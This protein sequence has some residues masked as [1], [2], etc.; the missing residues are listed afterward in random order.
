MSKI[1][2]GSDQADRASK[3]MSEIVISVNKVAEIVSEIS[4]ASSEQHSGIHE[5][6]IAVGQMDQV[7]QQNAAL[8]EQ[9]AAAAQSLTEQSVELR[10]AV[11]FFR[12]A[13]A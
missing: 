6:G 8:V 2:E 1:S 9:A 7:T 4:T 3:A 12:T 10:N 13:T 5:V 11:R